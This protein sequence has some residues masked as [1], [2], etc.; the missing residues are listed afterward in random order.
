MEEG[1]GKKEEA[2]RKEKKEEGGA[3]KREGREK[4]RI[5]YN[6]CIKVRKWQSFVRSIF[7]K[8]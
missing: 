8:N 4:L 1:G 2:M 3:R 5:Y 6:Y 7:V